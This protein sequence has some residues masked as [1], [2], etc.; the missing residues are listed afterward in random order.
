[1]ERPGNRPVARPETLPSIRPENRPSIRPTERPATLPGNVTFPRPGDR[2]TISRPDISLPGGISRPGGAVPLP[3]GLIR[4]GGGTGITR[5]EITRPGGGIVRPDNTL[6]NLTR[7]GGSLNRPGG[8]TLPD[9][10]INNRPGWGNDW[11]NLN[12]PGNRPNFNNNLNNNNINVNIRNNASWSYR[13]NSWGSR[14]WWGSHHHHHWHHGRWCYGWG[15]SSR[16]SWNNGFFWGVTAWSMGNWIFNSG[17]QNFRNPFPAPPVINHAGTTIINYTRPITVVAAEF[18]P[19]DEATELAASEKSDAAMEEALTAFKQGE[20]EAARVAVDLA[21][22]HVPGDAA[23]HEFR[24]LVFFAMGRFNDAA[25][26]LNPILASGPGWDWT[27]MTGLFNSQDDY[28]NLLRNLEEHHQKNPDSAAANFLLGYHYLVLGHLEQ[29]LELFEKS[30][31]LEPTDTVSAGLRDLIRDSIKS[32]EEGSEDA[33]PPATV[34]PDKLVGTWVCTV[35]DDGTITLVMTK[36]GG[37]TWSFDKTGDSGKQSGEFG[38]Q[39][40]NL[41]V[42][43]TE[44][45]QM[46]GEVVLTEDSKFSFVLAG[47]PRGDPGLTFVRKP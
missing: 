20:Y 14:P 24:A 19:A 3:E 42:L 34:N 4:P 6:P 11:G 18:P 41:L 46:A 43:I 13:P 47:G 40:P 17:Y 26:V 32:E 39:D 5:P 45:A 10:N 35:V 44:D 29:A 38:I 36:E 12:R 7:P 27:T 1:V 30:A 23:L 16:S 33:P 15:R 37:F 21:I 8:N 31:K 2:P 9:L 28:V 22:S 25:G